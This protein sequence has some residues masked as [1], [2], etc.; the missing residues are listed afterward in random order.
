VAFSP[1]GKTVLTGSQDGTA[2]LWDP[3]TGNALGQPFKHDGP[4]V[5]VAFSPDGEKALTGSWD[6]TAKLWDV[7][8]KGDAPVPHKAPPNG[9]QAPRDEADPDPIK[10]LPHEGRVES[11][12]FSPDGN[13]IATGST[14]WDGRK[15]GARLWAVVGF[16]RVEL[17]PPLP[18]QKT[19]KIVVFSPDGRTLATGSGDGDTRLWQAD[20]GELRGKAL[21]PEKPMHALAFSP[22]WETALTD[23]LCGVDES[24]AEL[25]LA[26]ISTGE[27]VGKA[28]KLRRPACTAF[29]PDGTKVLTGAG[30]VDLKKGGTEWG[31]A[32]L[33]DL[34]TNQ[35][36]ILKH[37]DP[38]RTVA[39]SP[40]GTMA[41]TGA[42][43]EG[44]TRSQIRLWD[45]RMGQPLDDRSFSTQGELKALTF[46]P[47][48]KI[49]LTATQ[50]SGGAGR[51]RLELWDVGTGKCRG[52]PCRAQDQIVSLAL[53]PDSMTAL[54]GTEQKVGQLWDV[55]TG[56]ARRLDLLLQHRLGGFVHEEDVLVGGYAGGTNFITVLSPD[57]RAILTVACN[58]GTVRL[59]EARTGRAIGPPLLHRTEIVAAG[60]G[61]GGESVMV[62]G[63]DGTVREW[64]IPRPVEGETERVAVWT[65]V[66]TG[67]ELDEYGAVRLLDAGAWEERRKRLEQLGGPPG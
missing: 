16:R 52:S 14:G 62:G 37:E 7:V 41:V 18:H 10:V 23:Q 21:K 36:T 20:V 60:F 1:D 8:S 61:R 63:M 32:Q 43:Q 28:L 11:V 19:V 45:T 3:D 67:M 46:S 51:A 31:E 47:D 9:D 33:W 58:D 44:G 2:R 4:V 27:L 66:I 38:V 64:A 34:T 50:E 12:A 25:Q 55:T 39:F 59:W 57:G 26:K 13:L 30:E 40:E 56:T 22:D 15:G 49:L 6:K 17:C 53:S 65:Q 35:T 54:T 42:V 29:S 48:G 5:A 24:W